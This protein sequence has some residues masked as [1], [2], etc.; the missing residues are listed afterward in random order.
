MG[1]VFKRRRHDALTPLQVR[2]RN[3]CGRQAAADILGL[4]C[5]IHFACLPQLQSMHLAFIQHLRCHMETTYHQHTA[6][7]RHAC[8]ELWHAHGMIQ[9][10]AMQRVH[11]YLA[12]SQVFCPAMQGSSSLK[13]PPA[14][15]RWEFRPA[16]HTWCTHAASAVHLTAKARGHMAHLFP[17]PF[18]HA[19]AQMLQVL[20]ELKLMAALT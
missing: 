16:L 2:G 18:C 5:I 20:S 9:S 3:A 12:S 17:A 10:A 7:Q 14:L 1:R 15:H 13:N 4:S 19:C 8:A 6:W 11:V